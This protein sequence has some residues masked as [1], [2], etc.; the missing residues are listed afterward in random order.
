MR[1]TQVLHY[2]YVR[3]LS[4]LEERARAGLDYFDV[5]NGCDDDLYALLLLKSFEGCE[6]LKRLL[7]DWP[8]DEIRMNSTGSFTLYESIK[9]A[10][11]FYA[12]VVTWQRKYGSIPIEDAFVLDYGCGWGR[13][14]RFF[15]KSVRAGRLFGCDPNPVFFQLCKDLRVPG[16]IKLSDWMSTSNVFE[17]KFD[18]VYAFSIFTHTSEELQF[19]ILRLLKDSMRP[20]GLVVATIRPGAFLDADGGETASWT[21]TERQEG[22]DA[23]RR[24]D[25]AYWPYPQASHWG[26]TVIPESYINEHWTEAFSLLEIGH[27]FQNWTQ[28]P[29][30]LRRKG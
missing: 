16:K 5:F 28:V 23:Y 7:P 21:A 11:S 22:R 25:C 10:L 13:L 30:C 8:S 17:E 20:G 29:V 1:P 14:L 6:A 3:T 19:N 15:A 4:L 9:E 18:L 24:G 2:N 26:I 27:L 12:K